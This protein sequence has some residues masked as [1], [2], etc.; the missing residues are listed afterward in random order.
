MS[1]GEQQWRDHAVPGLAAL[2]HVVEQELPVREV[3]FPVARTGA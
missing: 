3:A 2:H 1:L